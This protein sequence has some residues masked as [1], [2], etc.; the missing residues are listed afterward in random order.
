MGLGQSILRANE[1]IFN[2]LT[3][4]CWGFP[5]LNPNINIIRI[6]KMKNNYNNAKG[7]KLLFT[8]F[9]L[10]INVTVLYCLK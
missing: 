6:I 1:P 8:N 9:C 10:A 7:T 4:F 2:N 5:P 3:T